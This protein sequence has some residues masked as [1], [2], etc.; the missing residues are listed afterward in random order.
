M[1]DIA[2]YNGKIGRIDEVQAPI[3]D[4]GLYFGDGVY[5]AAMVRNRNVF[6]LDDHLDRFY[7]SLRLLRIEPP[8]ER[9]ELAATL[10]DL[11]SRDGRRERGVLMCVSGSAGWSRMVKYTPVPEGETNVRPRRPRPPVCSSAASTKPCGWSRYCSFMTVLG[12]R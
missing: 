11:V 10:N 9:S 7:N 1:K 6:A 4:R 5:D 2:Y 8:M 12:S 3:T